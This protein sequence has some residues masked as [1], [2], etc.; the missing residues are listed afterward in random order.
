[1]TITRYA[2]TT[3]ASTSV[4][5][6]DTATVS[7]TAGRLQILL[8]L[9]ERPS[10][11]WDYLEIADGGCGLTWQTVNASSV[12]EVNYP[13]DVPGNNADLYMWWAM[14]PSNVA[15]G[16]ATLSGGGVLTWPRFAWIWIEFDGIDSVGTKVNDAFD[17][18]VNATASPTHCPFNASFDDPTNN[19]VVAGCGVY[20]VAPTAPAGYAATAKSSG[21]FYMSLASKVGEDLDPQFTYSSTRRWGAIAGEFNAAPPPWVRPKIVIPRG[22]VNRAAWR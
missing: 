6:A 21:S 20:G 2:V 14:A 3:G 15:S 8:G 16:H 11:D 5:S 19:L 1:M 12:Y 9:G 18:A 10:S 4:T 13:G 22:A 17:L 7:P